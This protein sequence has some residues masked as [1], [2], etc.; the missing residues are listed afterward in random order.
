MVHWVYIHEFH[1]FWRITDI[2]IHKQIQ[3]TPQVQSWKVKKSLSACFCHV[4]D[5]QLDIVVSEM[6]WK[7]PAINPLHP[8]LQP[9]IAPVLV[10]FL[11]DS[12][13]FNW[14]KV[15]ML[16]VYFT[17]FSTSQQRSQID[18]M[19]FA[20][21]LVFSLRKNGNLMICISITNLD[22]GYIKWFGKWWEDFPG[23]L[24]A[25]SLMSSI[26]LGTGGWCATYS[27]KKKFVKYLR[28]LGTQN[29]WPFEL[30]QSFGRLRESSYCWASDFF[31]SW[32]QQLHFCGASL[33]WLCT[34]P[35][36]ELVKEKGRHKTDFSI[37]R[38][39]FF[40][41]IWPISFNFLTSGWTGSLFTQDA[42][43]G[44]TPS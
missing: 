43:P 3:K 8:S 24:R 29:L 41:G 38:S 18:L 35:Q 13:C 6:H 17:P 25:M 19:D 44:D 5:V 28:L 33:S 2:K 30:F 22:F 39:V 16:M 34:Q 10:A 36:S 26:R 21:E 1:N 40:H 31:R 7:T 23:K 27:W 12:T 14:L 4:L 37:L 9:S 15:Q 11:V 42:T 32:T 20:A